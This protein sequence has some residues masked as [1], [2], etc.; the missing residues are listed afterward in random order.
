VP[1]ATA[2]GRRHAHTVDASFVY[3]RGGKEETREKAPCPILGAAVALATVAPVLATIPP[4][5]RGYEGQ[6]GNQ[7]GYHQTGQKG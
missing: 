3:Q 1:V 2:G 6:P 4:G 5:Q 7:G